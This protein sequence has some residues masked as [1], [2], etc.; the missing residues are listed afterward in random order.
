VSRWARGQAEVNAALAASQLQIITGSA[1]N[2]EPLLDQ[3]ER[4]L[5]SAGILLEN[6]DPGS[7][8]ILAY[9][10]A[11]YCGTAVLAHQGLRP[12]S[13]G[14]HYVVETILRAQFGDGFRKFGSMRR[15]RNELEYPTVPGDHTTTAEASTAIG[16]AQAILDA[17]RQL[18]PALGLYR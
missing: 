4:T 3:A 10:A 5:N 14:G 12:T 6:D 9:D 16:D 1:A 8:F 2:G 17:A 13:A 11:R 15:R 7:A 18:L